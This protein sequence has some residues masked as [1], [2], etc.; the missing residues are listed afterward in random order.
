MSGGFS[1][2]DPAAAL[3]RYLTGALNARSVTVGR[4]AKLSGG[5]IQENWA[6]DATVNGGP[7]AG[8]LALVMRTDAPSGVA[9]SHGRAHEFAI[10][11]VAHRAGMTVPEPLALC[12]DRAVLGKPFYVMRR[13]AGTAAGHI[14]TRD[15]KWKGDRA[16]LA[17]RLGRELARLHRV[18]PP[19]AE[20]S[21][22]GHPKA[23]PALAAIAEYRHWLD[24]YRDPRPALEWGLAW[25]A[26]RAPEPGA[27]VLC[28]RDFR[29]GNYMV[30]D[31][32]LTGVLDWE[33]AGWGDPMED[34]GWFC[35]R[36][37]RFGMYGA[38]AG[39]I[40]RREALYDGYEAEGGGKVDDGKVRFWEQMA[41][42]RWS[43][44]ALEQ[45]E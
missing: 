35:A 23:N 36:C 37:W 30:D 2:A 12:E 15:D 4:L 6:V 43:I 5:A 41:A 11:S 9:V 14:V 19:V 17:E 8:K 1:T 25:L 27:I 3:A 29:T 16:A 39:G 34:V 22:L 20:L 45:A 18:Q 38:E 33:F 42:L 21:F 26:E 28:H 44:M 24:G 7:H 13:I 10:L 32:G 31:G 40:G